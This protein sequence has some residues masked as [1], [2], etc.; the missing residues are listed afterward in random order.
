MIILGCFGGTTILG[1]TPMKAEMMRMWHSIMT[2]EN[3]MQSFAQVLHSFGCNLGM[4]LTYLSFSAI[5]GIDAPSATNNSYLHTSCNC[6]KS[7]HKHH[8]VAFLS[9]N[10]ILV[11]PCIHAHI[12]IRVFGIH[13]CAWS[14]T[15]E[16]N[17]T[18]ALAT[19]RLKHFFIHTLFFL[20]G[21]TL[22]HLSKLYQNP[23]PWIQAWHSA[24]NCTNHP[25][26]SKLPLPACSSGTDVDVLRFPFEA[27]LVLPNL[28]AAC[29]GKPPTP[30]FIPLLNNP[31]WREP[32]YF[33]PLWTFHLRDL[34]HGDPI[35][36]PRRKTNWPSIGT[37]IHLF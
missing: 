24:R 21:R 26:K 12:C 14:L 17:W 9:S 15:P 1:N 3:S 19:T 13:G 34:T 23:C 35:G 18:E 37:A 16:S 11:F 27:D 4:Q 2:C 20:R 25:S 5:A 36:E 30:N 29:C 7:N 33:Q 8:R 10:Q 22:Q 32:E 6:T 31:T 28:L